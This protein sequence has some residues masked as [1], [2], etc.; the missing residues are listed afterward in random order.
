[1]AIEIFRRE[2]EQFLRGYLK[3]PGGIP[4]HDTAGNGNQFDRLSGLLE[5][6][7][8]WVWPWHGDVSQSIK[9]RAL[10]EAQGVMKITPES[11][12]AILMRRPGDTARLFADLR[13][14]IIDEIHALMGT[15][16]GLQVLCLLS[17]LEKMADATQG[18]LA[19]R[20]H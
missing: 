13:F 17:R 9:N 8:I 5:D 10:K 12:E 11:L 6:S 20:Q 14:V 3:L 15:D 16:R 4:S 19:F 1:M 7:Y 18:V 2:H